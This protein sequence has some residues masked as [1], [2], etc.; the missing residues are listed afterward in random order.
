MYRIVQE[1]LTNVVKHA[2]ARRVSVRLHR[3]ARE[4]AI[5]VADDGRGPAGAGSG[6]G[7]GGHGL[8]GIRERAAAHGGTAECGPRRDGSGFEVRAVLV[9]SPLEVG[10]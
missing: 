3:G 2:G 7:S 8:I 5:T 1:A 9:T 4:L 10:N 6:S